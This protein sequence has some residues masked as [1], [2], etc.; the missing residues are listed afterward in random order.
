MKSSGP[1]PAIRKRP[2]GTAQW[3][4]L[5][6]MRKIRSG[7]WT[8]STGALYESKALTIQVLESLVAAGMMT[9]KAGL[10]TINATGRKYIDDRLKGVIPDTKRQ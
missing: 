2:I 3:V 9:E 5:Q 6:K 8:A 10:Y 4:V 1:R 7:K